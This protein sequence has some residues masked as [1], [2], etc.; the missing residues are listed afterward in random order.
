MIQ[1]DLEAVYF[2]AYL[3]DINDTTAANTT[4]SDNKTD[5][6]I[7]ATEVSK[8]VGLYVMLRGGKKWLILRRKRSR[9]KWGTIR[10]RRGIFLHECEDRLQYILSIQTHKW[11]SSNNR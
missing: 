10:N 7:V 2:P 11:W 5:V 6:R 3:K 1:S 4:P 8:G 9:S